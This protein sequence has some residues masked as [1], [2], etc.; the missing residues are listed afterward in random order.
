[1][2]YPFSGNKYLRFFARL[3]LVYCA[4]VAILYWVAGPQMEAI[5]YQTS[6]LSPAGN[7]GGLVGT[8]VLEQQFTVPTDTLDEIQ[9]YIGTFGRPS[10]SFFC[11]E[12]LDVDGQ[13]VLWKQDVWAENL[14]NLEMNSFPLSNPLQDVKNQTLLL[15]ISTQDV[16]YETAV[17]FYYGNAVSTGRGQIPVDIEY[18]LTIN[19][20]AVNASLCLSLIGRDLIVLKQLY[21]PVV[22]L[23][24]ISLSIAYW[25]SYT[26]WRQ[27]K[28]SIF[29][30]ILRLNKY[31]FLIR[32]LVTRDFKTKYKRSFLGVLWSFLNP[33][34]TM[35]VQYLIFSSLFQSSIE[36]FAVYLL[37]GGIIFNF[38]SEAVGLGL[39]SIVSNAPL[40]TK[41]YVP[42]YIY[43]VSRVLSSSVN[44]LISMIPLCFMVL[45][46]GIPLSKSMFLFPLVLL[47]TVVFC[48]GVSLLLSSSMVFFRD[49]QFLWGIVSM[50]WM[51][52]TPIFYPESIIPQQF[53]QLYHM[54]PLYQF[55]Y[56]LRAIIMD[57]QAPGPYTFLYCT[58]CAA[59]P[60]FLGLWVF[61]KTQ[62]RFVFY[63]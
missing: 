48:I 28:R 12:I 13:T 37:T 15:R 46:S 8:N 23:L 35:G 41:V 26:R 44:A 27:G 9:L 19:G 25:Y 39:M 32:Q 6:S 10:P 2:N 14:K 49:T 43:P 61:R 11:I 50:L 22:V 53:L 5:T 20:Q 1:M 7:D 30:A 34:L 38:F 24:G 31:S 58:L 42:K 4:C 63:L 56:F 21:W 60:L 55:I 57:G 59:V 3:I 47:Y 36:N 16:A 51:Y 33:L 45:I 52:M 18:P 40:I 54:N 17:T 29:S 62:D